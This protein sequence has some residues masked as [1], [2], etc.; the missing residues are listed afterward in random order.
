[1]KTLN[2]SQSK[3]TGLEILSSIKALDCSENS[4]LPQ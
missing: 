2:I 1:M 3:Q 4:L